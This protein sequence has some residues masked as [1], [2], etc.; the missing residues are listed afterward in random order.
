MIPPSPENRAVYETLEKYDGTK[1]A[2][3]NTRTG[4]MRITCWI[5]KVT[6]IHS[7][8]VILIAFPRQ[9]L[10]PERASILRYTYTACLVYRAT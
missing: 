10:L 5:T 2:T 6:N 7:Q 1:D 4:R 3:D 8:Y 9:T